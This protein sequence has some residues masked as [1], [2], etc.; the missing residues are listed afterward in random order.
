[1]NN[2]EPE[3]LLFPYLSVVINGFLTGIEQS[4]VLYDC[5]SLQLLHK[6]KIMKKYI[7][8]SKIKVQL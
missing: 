6:K 7:T 5:N 4:S 3:S 2:A 8:S 1:M